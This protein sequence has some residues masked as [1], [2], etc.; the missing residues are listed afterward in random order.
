MHYILLENNEIISILNYEP[1][2]PDS[3]EKI[4]ITDEEYDLIAES[5]THYFDV[6]KKS[7]EPFDQAYL[8]RQRNQ[9][10]QDVI[11]I[12]NLRFLDSSDWKVLRHIRQKALGITTSLT[13]EEYLALEQQRTEAAARIVNN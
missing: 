10:Q 7:I 11:N 3:V 8:D 2:I 5:K 6:V 9:D 1:S 12:E 13:E 4:Q